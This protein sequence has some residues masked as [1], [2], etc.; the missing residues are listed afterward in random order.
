MVSAKYYFPLLHRPVLHI[1]SLPL[2][3]ER[4]TE[5]AFG[6][7]LFMFTAPFVWYDLII[8]QGSAFVQCRKVIAYY[9][10]MLYP[11]YLKKRLIDVILFRREHGISHISACKMCDICGISAIDIVYIIFPVFKYLSN[12]FAQVTCSAKNIDRFILREL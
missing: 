4:S 1:R 5:S 3:T 11:Q 9:R 6:I 12:F 2:T 7:L 8:T 10:K